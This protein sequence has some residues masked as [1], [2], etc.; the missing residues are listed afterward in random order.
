MYWLFASLFLGP[1]GPS[2]LESLQFLSKEQF[3]SD[4][5]NQSLNEK[6]KELTRGKTI[7]QAAIQSFVEKLKIPD[8]AKQELL[9][10]SPR[11]Y[12]GNAAQQA[13]AL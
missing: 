5:S 10:L 1:P 12:L 2:L 7:D 8:A 11:K 9:E 13:K 3:F 6:L 4:S